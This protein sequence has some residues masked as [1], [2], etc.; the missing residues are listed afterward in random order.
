MLYLATDRR[1]A[2]VDPTVS[3]VEEAFVPGV[4]AGEGVAADGVRVECVAASPARPERAFAGTAGAGLFRTT[5]GGES[6]SGVALGPAADDVDA[7]HVTAVAVA[8]WDPDVVFAGT[9]PSR[10]YRSTDGG[11]SFHHLPGL[12][13]LPSSDEW[14]FPPRPHTHHVRWLE[15]DPAREGRVLVAV[16]AGAL[17]VLDVGDGTASFRE[18]PPGARRDTHSMATHPDAPGRAYAAAGDG[19]AESRRHGDD[20][21]HPQAGL[22]H[23]YCWSVAVDPADPDVRLVS[24]ASGVRT[25]HSPGRAETYVYRKRGDE[26]WTL[27]TDG[28]GDPEGRTRAVLAAGDD[29]GEF[30]AVSNRGLYRTTDAGASWRALSVDVPF[31]EGGGTASGLVH[32]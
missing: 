14:A 32:V 21:D 26:P 22:D 3:A 7:S 2:V 18:R 23:R 9:E 20:W 8:P 25:A 16:E 13:E 10:V 29:A 12:V 4:D 30:Y 17:V 19:Y 27:A 1:V 6:W 31:G 24:A 5:D 15:P 11:E 28:L